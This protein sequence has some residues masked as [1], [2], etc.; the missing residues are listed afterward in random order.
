MV[1]ATIVSV[2]HKFGYYT[3]SC[4]GRS[5]GLMLELDVPCST[6]PEASCDAFRL[7]VGLQLVDISAG[8]VL[9]AVEK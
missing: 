9:K 1:L 6:F 2:A 3:D 8:K 4:F 7:A 5:E